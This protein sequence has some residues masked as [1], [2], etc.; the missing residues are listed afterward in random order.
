MSCKDLYLGHFIG[1]HKIYIER[2]MAYSTRQAYFLICKRIA[3][4]H[5][6]PASVVI[7]HFRLGENCDVKLEI[8]YEE[9]EDA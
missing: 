4:K 6:L 8:K 1:P 3:K 5:G 9:V 7:D 2:C